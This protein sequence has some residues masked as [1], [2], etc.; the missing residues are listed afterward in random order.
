MYEHLYIYLIYHFYISFT[1]HILVRRW[2]NLTETG[3][4]RMYRI[5]LELRKAYSNFLDFDRRQ[6][7]AFS[8]PVQR[9]IES[10]E[11]T[12]NALMDLGTIVDDEIAN[13]GASEAQTREIGPTNNNNNNSNRKKRNF[14]SKDISNSLTMNEEQQFGQADEWQKVNI[15][16]KT[17]PTLSIAY[18]LSCSLIRKRA[19]QI[20]LN[21]VQYILE[22]SSE[23]DSLVGMNELERILEERYGFRGSMLRS[24]ISLLYSTIK[25]ELELRHGK[26]TFNC[27]NH[28]RDWFNRPVAT[29]LVNDDKPRE[30]KLTLFDVL[31]QATLRNFINF[32]GHHDRLLQ[33]GPI[34]KSILE[35]QLVALGLTSR[36]GHIYE[37]KKMIFYSTHDIVFTR[38]LRD[39]SLIRT[40]NVLSFEDRFF[41]IKAN[42]DSITEEDKVL[43]GMKPC[44]YGASLR[45]ELWQVERPLLDLK[46]TIVKMSIYS[47]PDGKYKEINYQPIKI[48]SLCRSRFLKR[49]M[50]DTNSLSGLYRPELELNEEFDC[51]FELFRDL[52]TEYQIDHA[53]LKRMCD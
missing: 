42:L 4:L 33:S 16:L 32:R 51:P 28:F 34:L 29:R 44:S 17:V 26:G 41:A 7:L 36:T 8:S 21:R 35:S 11:N 18:L 15:D 3:K 43:A 46:A 48:G 22:N 50:T 47:Q 19:Y 20:G 30:L 2:G 38:L 45:I 39:L 14:M 5:G 27:T 12:L 6:I 52:I 24:R 25:S 31:E 23:L 49:H 53:S 10:L 37:G 40:T 9:C 1:A 13:L